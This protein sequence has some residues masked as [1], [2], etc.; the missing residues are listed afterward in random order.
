MLE[1]NLPDVIESHEVGLYIRYAVYV[2]LCLGPRH[3]PTL[4]PRDVALLD[5]KP[6]LKGTVQFGA[7]WSEHQRNGLRNGLPCRCHR[8]LGHL[9]CRI[10]NRGPE[11]REFLHRY[12]YS[13]CF[14]MFPQY[15]PV[16]PFEVE[17]P[18]AELQPWGTILPLAVF[19]RIY[20]RQL[21]EHKHISKEF[22]LDLYTCTHIYQK[23]SKVIKTSQSM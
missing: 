16:F 3:H 18:P 7:L 1:R 8:R 2:T 11:F 15:S 4:P 13:T 14:I 21:L 10:C 17:Y 5:S 23:Y 22:W 12:S 20:L 19:T 9:T 6:P